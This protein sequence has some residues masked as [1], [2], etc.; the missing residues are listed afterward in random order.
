MFGDFLR[1]E[2]QE[3]P[4]RHH[5]ALHLRQPVELQNYMGEQLFGEHQV[6]RCLGKRMRGGVVAPVAHPL[7]GVPETARVDG[8]S[9]EC[10]NGLRGIATFADSPFLGDVD[11]D[12]EQPG[13]Q[14][15]STFECG[16]PLAQC[17]PGLLHYLFGDLAASHIAAR[18]LQHRGRV[19]VHNLRERAL[20]AGL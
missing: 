18:E 19:R 4:H 15:R 13:A 8:P 7:A 20:V 9:G 2:S 12:G 5:D 3:V 17:E 14:R 1:I 6:L 16:D 10:R 11:Q